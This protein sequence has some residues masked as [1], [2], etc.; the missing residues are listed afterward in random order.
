MQRTVLSSA[1]DETIT[2]LISKARPLLFTMKDHVEKE[3]IKLCSLGVLQPCTNADFDWASPHVVSWRENGKIRLCCDLRKVNK[4]IKK[5]PNPLPNIESTINSIT[6]AKVYSK[7][8]L[9]N[10]YHQ[11]A[12]DSNTQRLLGFVSPCELYKFLTAPFRLRDVPPK[13]QKLM[14]LILVDLK[15][16]LTVSLFLVLQRKNMMKD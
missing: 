15:G 3:V 2:P 6:N 11:F 10:A 9:S 14:D 5:D 4:T 13:F 8:D 1:I 16:F 7:T 12:V